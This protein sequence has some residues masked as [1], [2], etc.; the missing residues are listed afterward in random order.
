MQPILPGLVYEHT[1]SIGPKA[2]YMEKH[3][4]EFP[5]N[6]YYSVNYEKI[7]PYL[8]DSIK[9]LNSKIEVLEAKLGE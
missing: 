6:T 5:D 2:R 8:V 7:V 4:D 1:G 9:E 3:P